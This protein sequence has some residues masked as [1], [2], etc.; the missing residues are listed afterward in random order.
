MDIPVTFTI[1][2]INS[3]AFSVPSAQAV[4]FNIPFGARHSTPYTGEY[5]VTPTREVQTIHTAGKLMLEDL[6]ID[7]I[8]SN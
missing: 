2:L 5:V 6:I 3:V 4:S 8:P 1:P 7:P